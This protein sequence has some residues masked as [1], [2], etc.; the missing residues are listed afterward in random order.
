VKRPLL[1]GMKV[2]NLGDDQWSV[3]MTQEVRDPK[4]LSNAYHKAWHDKGIG[5]RVHM[6]GEE[7][8]F[9]V[10]SLPAGYKSDAER[11]AYLLVQREKPETVF[12]A[13]HEPFAGGPDKAAVKEFKR[14]QQ[15]DSAVAVRITGEGINDRILL[16]WADGAE[17]PCTL[18]DKK[19]SF[20]FTGYGYVRIDAKTV[21]ASGNITAIRIQVGDG[22][23][24]LMLNGKETPAE[25]KRGVLTFPKE[26]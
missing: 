10:P 17:S 1:Q 8:T 3:T 14:I 4:L 7:G 21:T 22:K 16:A 6:L 19:E 13:L 24:A 15:T 9:L 11:G 2:A 26:T 23:P 20:T 12:V 5:V 25:V 18:G